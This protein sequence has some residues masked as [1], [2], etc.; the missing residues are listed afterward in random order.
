MLQAASSKKG[1][2]GKGGK[3]KGK[4]KTPLAAATP[5]QSAAAPRASSKATARAGQASS[6]VNVRSSTQATLVLFPGSRQPASS[7][8]KDDDVAS[9]AASL[10]GQKNAADRLKHLLDGTSVFLQTC[11]GQPA[12]HRLVFV[13]VVDSRASSILRLP[14]MPFVMMIY[15][16]LADLLRRRRSSG[17]AA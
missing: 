3:G 5:S 9:V 15:S 4:G 7:V 12:S 14:C 13:F 11:T 6:S 1:R 10:P 2:G 16:M 8:E 17:S